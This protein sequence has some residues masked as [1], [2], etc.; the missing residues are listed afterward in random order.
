MS[1]HVMV[2]CRLACDGAIVRKEF[3]TLVL[4]HRFALV[5]FPVCFAVPAA[6]FVLFVV[7]LPQ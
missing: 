7:S 1:M 5:S 6:V 2:L 4:T 3:K